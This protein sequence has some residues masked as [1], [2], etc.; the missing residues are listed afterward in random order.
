MLSSSDIKKIRPYNIRM[1]RMSARARTSER[2]RDR[3]RY[4]LPDKTFDGVSWSRGRSSV[5][6][7]LQVRIVSIHICCTVYAS[8]AFT[9]CRMCAPSASKKICSRKSNKQ[10][11]FFKIWAPLTCFAPTRS[12]YFLSQIDLRPLPKVPK[13]CPFLAS[14]CYFGRKIRM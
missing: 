7:L 6:C 14:I 3:E 8:G 2:E 11:F 9:G 1:K 13:K 10:F 4:V 12:Q 5:T